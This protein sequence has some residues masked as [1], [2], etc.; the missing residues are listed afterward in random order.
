MASISFVSVN[1]EGAKHLDLVETFLKAQ[2]PEVVCIQ[3]L[4]ERDIERISASLGNAHAKFLPMMRR[5]DQRGDMNLRGVG[6]FTSLPIT[7]SSLEFYRGDPAA[8]R[9]YDET[10]L[11]TKYHTQNLGVLF[12]EVEKDGIK[13]KIGTTHFTWTP[14]G[15]AND[16]QR[17][18]IKALISVLAT[19]GEFVLS[20][21]F[22]APRIHD[23][24]RGEIFTQLSVT[25]K[26]NIPA[27]YTT[28]L[29]PAY[30]RAP[31][32]EQAD[33][34]VDGLFST[35]SYTATDVVLHAGVSDHCAITATITRS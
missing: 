25:Y 33:K 34:M 16:F 9:D 2:A 5:D 18:D 20:G 7:A 28:S 13:F 15:G 17:I 32:A 11:D 19:S 24:V 27:S 29:D 3:E 30:H 23:G 22:N 10:S 8:L 21:D 6:I 26:D 31:L 1:I 12:C 14:K 35:P 4:F